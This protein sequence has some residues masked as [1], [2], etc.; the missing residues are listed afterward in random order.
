M[1]LIFENEDRREESVR[2]IPENLPLSEHILI[3][4]RMRNG[5]SCAHVVKKPGAFFRINKSDGSQMLFRPGSGFENFLSRVP[6]F[7]IVCPGF[8]LK[9]SG[10]RDPARAHPW[11]L[12]LSTN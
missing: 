10:F 11:F 3:P 6:G 9:F 1:Q 2:S 12:D 4:G 7:E 5:K 8:I